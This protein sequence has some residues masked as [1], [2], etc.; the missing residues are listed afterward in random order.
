MQPEQRFQESF[1]S[2]MTSDE[3]SDENG[4]MYEKGD[5]LSRKINQEPSLG[6]LKKSLLCVL[7]DSAV[8]MLFWESMV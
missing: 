4:S 3:I 6:N 8:K 5:S 2:D 7:C 1:A